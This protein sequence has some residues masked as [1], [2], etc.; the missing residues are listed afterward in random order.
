MTI[1]RQTNLSN[2][3]IYVFDPNH[4]NRTPRKSQWSISEIEEQ[5]VFEDS[6]VKQ[7]RDGPEGWGVYYPEGTIDYLGL[8]HTHSKR[9]FIAK[10]R[11]NQ[12][13]VIWHGYP[14]D[15]SYSTYDT[16]PSEIIRNWLS[17]GLISRPK[18]SKVIQGKK[19][20]L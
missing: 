18:A 5:T 20:N 14:V 4:R 19:C 7:W 12:Q 8:D 16:P 11:S 6:V 3:F 9:V 13:E 17:N 15:H 10:F 1:P 2:G